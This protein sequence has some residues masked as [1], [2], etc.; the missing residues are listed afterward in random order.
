MCRSTHGRRAELRTARSARDHAR[1]RRRDGT[2]APLR[3][4]EDVLFGHAT[5]VEPAD[6]APTSS[7]PRHLL[8]RHGEEH[9]A[10]H[11]QRLGFAIVARNYRTRHGELDLVG[12]LPSEC[13]Q[14][15]AVNPG[16]PRPRDDRSRPKCQE[17]PLTRA[18]YE[19]AG[20]HQTLTGLSPRIGSCPPPTWG[21]AKICPWAPGRRGDC[22]VVAPVAAPRPPGLCS[23]SIPRYAR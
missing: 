18:T 17:A 2:K 16:S 14:V 20:R 19:S 22:A 4:H 3:W 11:L 5:R 21:G 9:A 10:R 8:G 6:M 12:V 7:D 15:E 23:L 13:F 1:R